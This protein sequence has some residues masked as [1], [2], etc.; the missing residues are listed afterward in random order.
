MSSTSSA[1]LPQQMNDIP[2]ANSL[3]MQLVAH[4]ADITR[5]RIQALALENS[6]NNLSKIQE[7]ESIRALRGEPVGTGDKAI[8]IAAGPSLKRKQVAEQI[9]A[10]DYQGAIIATESSMLYCLRQGIIPDLVVT[11]DP[12]P[13][14]IVRWF[15]D[16]DLTEADLRADD[17]FERQDLDTSFSEA[18]RTNDEILELLNKYGPQ[19]NIAVSSS[20][21]N[22]VVTRAHQ[23]GMH[24]YWWN[25]MYDDPDQEGSITRALQNE[26]GLPCVN[27]G[28]NVG[29][30]AWMMANAVW[31]KQRIA[32]TGMDLGYYAETPYKNTQYYHEAISLVGEDKLDE[33]FMKVYNPYLEK[34]FYTDPAYMWY[35]EC[36]LQMADH[37]NCQTFNC[38][39]GGIL[40]GDN[41]TF[42]NLSN[43]L[44]N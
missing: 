11:V 38:T 37:A 41:I 44:S 35:R 31:N 6:R 1:S 34:W 32:V 24:V 22:T 17:Y 18:L 9:I 25:P 16:P 29:A 28:G 40:F 27:A 3:G 26:N 21:A 42:T 15:G 23:S 5:D 39:E 2:D 19:I 13:K 20:S 33:L 12:H 7:G 43:F 8:I 10:S 30:A 36:F 4:M 14:R